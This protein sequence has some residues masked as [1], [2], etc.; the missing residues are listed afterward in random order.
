[1]LKYE[2]LSPAG[3][4]AMLSAAVDAGADAVYFGIQGF[5]MRA[6]AKNF[7]VTDLKEIAECLEELKRVYNRG[8]SSGFFIKMPTNDDF[9]KSDF[10]FF[11]EHHHR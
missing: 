1:M 11:A 2:L 8:F 10:I 6:A 3:N 9:S 4:F 5:N 7:A